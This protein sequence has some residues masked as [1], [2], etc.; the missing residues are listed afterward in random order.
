MH[1]SGCHDWGT[2][3][4]Q[5]H[6][7][8]VAAASAAAAAPTRLQSFFPFFFLF[9]LF[10]RA[11]PSLAESDAPHLLGRA[12]A[13]ALA[14]AKMVNDAQRP[15]AMPRRQPPSTATAT[16]CPAALLSCGLDLVP[17][18]GHTQPLTQ[19]TQPLPARRV[20]RPRRLGDRLR[21]P[22]RPPTKHA[23]L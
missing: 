6:Y 14:S 13:L 7:S 10:L 5:L 20:S 8:V 12:A 15:A 4:H 3:R 22:S 11:L 1:A 21:S 2:D 23:F 19:Q 18:H 17:L 16:S 9:F